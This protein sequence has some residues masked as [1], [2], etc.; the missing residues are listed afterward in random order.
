MRNLIGLPLVLLLSF[1]FSTPSSL[2]QVTYR[3][4]FDATW[5]V[6]THGTGYPSS[7]HFSPLIGIT[8]DD[9]VSFWESGGIASSGIEQMA[10]TGGTSVFRNELTAATGR[11]NFL[12]TPTLFSPAAS[13][14]EFDVEAGESLLTLVTMVAPSPDWFVGVTGLDLRPGGNWVDTHVVDLFVYD[15][16]T[17]SGPDFRSPNADV[18]PHEPIARLANHPVSNSGGGRGAPLSL[19]TFTFTLLTVPEPSSAVLLSA[20]CMVALIRR[21][22]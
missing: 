15:A 19:G 17:D 6:A 20:V 14:L 1:A 11:S 7:A 21:K 3:L 8:H 4:D 2:G 13:S 12:S 18:T 9:S 16:G 5:S 22:R 10:E